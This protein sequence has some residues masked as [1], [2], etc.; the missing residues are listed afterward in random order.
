MLDPLELQLQEAL[1]FSGPLEEQH[2]LLTADPSLQSLSN[3]Q[4]AA[5]YSPT[6]MTKFKSIIPILQ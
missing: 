6:E 2:M 4:F 1:G 3:K 5:I